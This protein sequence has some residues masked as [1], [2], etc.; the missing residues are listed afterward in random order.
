MTTNIK[1]KILVT[2]SAF[3]R[4]KGEQRD[5]FMLDLCRHLAKMFEVF[6]LVPH[7]KG[8]P[9]WEEYD[10]M[11]IIKHPQSPLNAVRIAYGSGI[12]PNIRRNKW[13]LFGVPFYFLYQ[14]FYIR[15]ICRKENIQLVNAHWVIPQGLVAVLYKRFF[16][17]K[18]KLVITI[19]G[20]DLLG[21]S[22]GI[23]G[24]LQR[25]S[26][27]NCNQIIAVSS[28]LKASLE[29]AGFGN[30]TF[31]RS[32][33]IDIRQ[34]SPEFINQDIRNNYKISGPFLLF[35]GALIPR[36]DP[37]TLIRAL[38]A[39]LETY[40][41]AKLMLIGDGNLLESLQRLIL[42]LNIAPSVIF[43]GELPY[44]KLPEY[45]ATADVFIL[46][47]RMEGLGLVVAESMAA[48][49]IVIASDISPIHDLITSEIT[50]FFFPPGNSIALAK[51]ILLVLKQMDSLSD[52]K[53]AA[54]HHVI[55]GFS[56]DKVV[57]EYAGYLNL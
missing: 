35:V 10:G 54:R 22:R 21:L 30:K 15:H 53:I 40:P 17:R 47:T 14:L 4:K 55:S 29:S 46:P 56:W 39:V 34:F 33:G 48:G 37:E 42:E 7:D 36:K 57:L 5:M 8:F 3:P 1:Q 23:P 32:M 2:T 9:S 25:Y 26:L 18:I 6:V 51:Q 41:N 20:T 31:V 24:K 28:A 12:L 13:L 44:G 50:G 16:C 27:R 43:T 19:H 45:F 38:P 52:L 49:T 11:H